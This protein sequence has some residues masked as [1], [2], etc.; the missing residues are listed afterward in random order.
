[1]LD[2]VNL[3]VW[4]FPGDLAFLQLDELLYFLEDCGHLADPEYDLLLCVF[5][6]FHILYLPRPFRAR[7]RGN[8]GHAPLPDRHNPRRRAFF[9]LRF[10]NLGLYC[11][12]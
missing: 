6:A 7:T 10:V 3:G 4:A 12:L 1:M 2:A 8:P 5:P 11:F 9:G